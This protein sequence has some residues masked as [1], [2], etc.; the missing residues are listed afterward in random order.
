MRSTLFAIFL[1]FVASIAYAASDAEAECPVDKVGSPW[2]R[3]CFESVGDVLQVKPEYRHR[4]MPNASGFET[5]LVAE[6]LELFAVNREGV[7]VV[8]GIA[9]TGDFDYPRAERGVGRFYSGGKCGYF[10][11][12]SFKIVVPAIYDACSAF[13][14]GKAVVCSECVRYCIGEE[15]KNEQF[16]G[17]KGY[18]LALN[19]KV[20]EE[21]VPS[22]L[23][24]ACGPVGVAKATTT[25]GKVPMLVCNTRPA[26]RSRK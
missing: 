10:Q 25:Y 19:G 23:E 5:I 20:I 14:E 17:G 11:S 6:P 9:H 12:K 18:E 1:I 8:P 15:C 2:S 16:V 24:D 13:R 7:V 21:F 22:T 4:V 3:A 26:P